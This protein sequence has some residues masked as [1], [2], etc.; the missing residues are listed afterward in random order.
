M[1]STIEITRLTKNELNMVDK[2]ILFFYS[3]YFIL[4][5]IYLW[6]SGLPQISDL[7]IIFSI[8][9]YTFYRKFT[10]K[11][12]EEIKP[13]LL[14]GLLF[15]VWIIFINLIW[16]FRLQTIDNFLVSTFFYIYNYFLLFFVIALV[17]HYKN[18]LFKVTYISVIIS[19][20]IQFLIYIISGGGDGSRQVGFLN[21]PNQLGYYSL[22]ILAFLIFFSS[23]L[24]IKFY[25]FML[26]MVSSIILILA[27]LS[28]AA[29][30][31]MLG[32]LIL[33]LFVKN[34]K[35]KLKKK[36]VVCLALILALG[37]SMYKATDFFQ[38]NQLMNS[39]QERVDSIGEDADDNLEGRGYDRLYDHPEYWITG[40]G[41]GAYYRFKNNFE[42]HSTLGNLLISYGIVGLS[43]FV[44]MVLFALRNDRFRSTYIVLF[45]MVY[46]LTHNGIRNSLLWILLAL[47]ASYTIK[48]INE[49]TT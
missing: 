3:L 27:S 15:V 9:I 31:S 7:S 25:W 46:G 43:L 32:L 39:V 22:L 48:E 5:P 49:R 19:V 13:I 2:L 36:Y 17:N 33:Y 16:I 45:L 8:I 35:K 34:K 6:S 18:I 40:A 4:S 11:I 37:F 1:M 10:F 42:L 21:N 41:E 38:E 28:K 14:V 30:V 20:I 44:L 29:I 24:D 26:A 12:T 23:K 47:I